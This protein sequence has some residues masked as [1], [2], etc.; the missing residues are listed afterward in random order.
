MTETIIISVLTSLVA[1]FLYGLLIANKEERIRLYLKKSA[2]GFF[3]KR[4]VSALVSA[5]KGEDKTTESSQLAFL[6]LLSLLFLAYF[7]HNY[8]S[9]VVDMHYENYKY[10]NEKLLGNYPFTQQTLEE[11]KKELEQN[12]QALISSVE[13]VNETISYLEQIL[14][15]IYW[16]ASLY[17]F[18]FFILFR[19]YLLMRKRFSHEFDRYCIRI[20]GLASKKELAELAVLES[21]VKDEDSLKSLIYFTVQVAKRHDVSELSDTFDLWRLT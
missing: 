6:T 19:P 9:T 8:I 3:R 14:P 11:Q 16:A 2:H 5:I 20:Q 21:K 1:A 4:Y 12:K 18:Y 15:I 13:A 7:S 17:Y 10:V